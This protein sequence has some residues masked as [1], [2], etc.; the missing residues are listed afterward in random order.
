V[1]VQ[2]QV[3][4]PKG[5]CVGVGNCGAEL[6]ALETRCG[7][8]CPERT[9]GSVLANLVDRWRSCDAWIKSVRGVTYSPAPR[10]K[11]SSLLGKAL[12]LASRIRVPVAGPCCEAVVG[13]WPLGSRRLPGRA[14]NLAD[15]HW[16]LARSGDPC[17]PDLHTDSPRQHKC[18]PESDDLSSLHASPKFAQQPQLRKATSRFTVSTES[19][20]FDPTKAVD[21][22]AQV[23]HDACARR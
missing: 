12:V 14:L 17:R 19:G 5:T 18:L 23:E 4:R 21:I 11:A 13:R 10:T 22:G 6:I 15:P 8:V 3:L 2:V 7:T 1:Q 9:V 20:V 16:L